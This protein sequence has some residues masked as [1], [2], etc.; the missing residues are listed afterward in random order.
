MEC[1][2]LGSDALCFDAAPPAPELE[3]L[4]VAD[5]VPPPLPPPPP[6]AL[7]DREEEE[8]GPAWDLLM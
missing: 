6:W 3:E 1:E 2:E 5:D 8:E 4:W 7:L